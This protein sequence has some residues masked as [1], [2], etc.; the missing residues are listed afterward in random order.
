MDTIVNPLKSLEKEYG[1]A[2]KYVTLLLVIL[3]F[4]IGDSR[5]PTLE[6][7]SDIEEHARETRKADLQSIN[8]QFVR[9]MD[10]V[11]QV[12]ENAN[13]NRNAVSEVASRLSRIEAQLEIVIRNQDRGYERKQPQG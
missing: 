9:I 1:W 2:F 8:D 5:W 10:E 11:K 12:Q 4:Y 3:L 6:Y 13:T 7:L